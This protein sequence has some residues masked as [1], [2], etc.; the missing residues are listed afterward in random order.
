MNYK[1][2]GCFLPNISHRT[3]CKVSV[4]SLLNEGTNYLKTPSKEKLFSVNRC[5]LILFSQIMAQNGYSLNF[6]CRVFVFV[7]QI[8]LLKGRRYGIVKKDNLNGARV[9]KTLPHAAYILLTL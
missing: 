6:S 9:K 8:D 1:P 7:F 4:Q 2:T 3:L 5:A